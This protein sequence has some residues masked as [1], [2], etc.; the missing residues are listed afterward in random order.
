ME[1]RL[2]TTG[3]IRGTTRSMD[4]TAR[5]LRRDPTPA[6]RKP[7]QS[8]RGRRLDGLQFRRQHPLGPFILDFCCPAHRLVVEVDGDVHAEQVEYDADR[9]QH[10][11]R[12]GYRVLRVRND[13]VL[14]D[15]PA[16]LEQIKSAAR[17]R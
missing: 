16:V 8:L 1:A 2:K 6:E 13:E 17:S 11:E 3:R 7:W 4:A 15:M 12:F 9:T 10:L 14:T 5:A